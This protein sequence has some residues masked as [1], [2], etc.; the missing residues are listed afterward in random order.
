MSYKDT[1]WFDGD[2]TIQINGRVILFSDVYELIK[3]MVTTDGLF[4]V[5]VIMDAVLEQTLAELK[6][7][8]KNGRGGV[9]RG[10]KYQEF[11]EVLDDIMEKQ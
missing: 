7:I 5:I 2:D 11:R 4:E 1:Y 8:E 9:Y 6:V 10:A 3:D